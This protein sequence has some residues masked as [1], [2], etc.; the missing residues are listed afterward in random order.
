MGGGYEVRQACVDDWPLIRTFIDQTYGAGAP[1]KGRARWDWAFLDTPFARDA[2]GRVPVWIAL[3]NGAVAG[4]IALQPGRVWLDGAPHEAGW[5]VDVMVHPAHRG[6]GVGHL[7]QQ[8]MKETGRTLVTLT[9]AEAT[10]RMAEKAGCVTLPPVRQMV[11]IGRLRGR[12]VTDVLGPILERR[13]R[14][15]AVGRAFNR[16]GVGPALAARLAA[17]AAGAHRIALPRP[18]EADIHPIE[19]IDPAVADRLFAQQPTAIPG[20]WDRSGAFCRW[21]FDAEPVLRYQRALLMRG[22]TAAGQVVWRLPEP[23]ELPVGTLTDVLADP[24]DGP[25]IEAL[26]AYAVHAMAPQCEAIVAG[27]SHP[28]HLRALRRLGFV[29][30][31]THRPTVI[32]SDPAMLARCAAIDQWHFT[33]ADHDWDQVHPIEHQP[34]LQA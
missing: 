33:K 6:R 5:I 11:R 14:L 34:R 25:A 32:S 29:A 3:E 15:R 7:I 27:A 13:A 22:G 18:T 31:K 30:V 19:R 16:S 28:E 23:A 26:A 10:R 8:A 2:D 20:L 12:T 9:M 21:R 4:Q 1:F 24:G 17:A